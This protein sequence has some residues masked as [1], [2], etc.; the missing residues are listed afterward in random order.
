M[1]ITTSPERERKRGIL[2]CCC[3]QYC[4]PSWK[5]VNRISHGSLSLSLGVERPP[6]DEV[7]QQPLFSL[8]RYNMY[9]YFSVRVYLNLRSHV[10]LCI[11][12]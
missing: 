8:S 9:S 5:T 4:K 2:C 6:D 10:L 1:C 3:V 12:G 7:L 11:S